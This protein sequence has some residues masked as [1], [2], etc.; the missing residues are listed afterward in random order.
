MELG[1]SSGERDKQ[2][3]TKRERWREE[4]GRKRGRDSYKAEAILQGIFL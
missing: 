1:C 2:I 4:G 3:G